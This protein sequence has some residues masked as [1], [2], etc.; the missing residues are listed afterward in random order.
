MIICDVNSKY[1]S[2]NY[3][4]IKKP[5]LNGK[6][7]EDIKA[8]MIDKKIAQENVPAREQYV[9][10]EL[11]REAKYSTGLSEIIKHGLKDNTKLR[12]DVCGFVTEICVK[13]TAING[14]YYLNFINNN[15]GLIA[16]INIDYSL[17]ST[18]FGTPFDVYTN[19]I[20]K[21][22]VINS[23][24]PKV[25][26]ARAMSA[27]SAPSRALSAMSSMSLPRRAMSARSL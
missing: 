6:S 12:L 24:T 3:H 22:N 17:S 1:F 13:E 19:K 23:V 18:L 27:Q 2:F 11:P 20:P 16:D 5:D 8:E 26:S 9:Y 21:I 25:I 7:N 4:Y 14:Y 15:N 10:N